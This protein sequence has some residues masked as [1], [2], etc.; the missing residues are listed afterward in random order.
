MTTFG[1][2]CVVCFQCTT[3]PVFMLGSLCGIAPCRVPLV[4]ENEDDEDM[5][6]TELELWNQN[7][8]QTSGQEEIRPGTDPTGQSKEAIQTMQPTSRSANAMNINKE[9]LKRS[10]LQVDEE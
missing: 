5:R 6:N 10:L 1:D 2:V 8:N 7:Q 4:K 9:E 3:Y